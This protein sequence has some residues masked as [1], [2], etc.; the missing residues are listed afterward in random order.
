MRRSNAWNEEDEDVE[1]SIRLGFYWRMSSLIYKFGG[2]GNVKDFSFNQVNSIQTRTNT[3]NF[4]IIIGNHGYITIG[5]SELNLGD[6][7]IVIH[8]IL[9]KYILEEV[10]VRWDII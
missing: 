8:L 3:V 9:E 5:R 1:S 10:L 2:F 4:S 7:G 6:F